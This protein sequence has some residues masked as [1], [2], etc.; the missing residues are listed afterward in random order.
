V[1]AAILATQILGRAHPELRERV[2]AQ[3]AEQAAAIL[4]DPDPTTD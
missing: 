2:A 1:N 3:R 4:A